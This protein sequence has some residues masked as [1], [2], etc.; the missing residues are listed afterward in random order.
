VG[1]KAKNC[2]H[3]RIVNRTIKS[4]PKSPAEFRVKWREIVREMVRFQPE[5]VILSAGFDAHDEDPLADLQLLEDDFHWATELV[6]KACRKI[7]PDAPVPVVSAL[8]GGY[9]LEALASSVLV[10]AQA[11]AAGYPELPPPPPAARVR[12]PGDEVAALT[13]HLESLGLNKD[14]RGSRD[15]DI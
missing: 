1:D 10:H 9:D 8:E 3:R 4:G 14:G 7:N 15:D 12:Q 6:M 11:L 13:E 5:L 2:L